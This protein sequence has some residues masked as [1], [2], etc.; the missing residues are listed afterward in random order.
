ME[1]SP[2]AG[3]FLDLRLPLGGLLAFYGVVLL[4]YGLATLHP[5]DGEW[6]YNKSQGINV[7]LVW[8]ILMLVVGVVLLGVFFYKSRKG[9]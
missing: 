2:K 5:L 9:S 1:P 7:N 8:G 3:H 6:I 4:I